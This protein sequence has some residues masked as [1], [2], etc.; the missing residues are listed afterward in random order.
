Q[1]AVCDR[2]T[3][4]LCYANAG[5]PGPLHISARGCCELLEG[6]MPSGMFDSVRYALQTVQLHPGD[7]ALFFT[8][9]LIEA[10][11]AQEEEFGIEQLDRKSTRLNSSHGSISYAVFCW[12]KKQNRR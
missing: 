8:D 11:N 10:R 7:A 12:K 5:L 9:G 2:A 4:V 6:G 3:Q 1:Y